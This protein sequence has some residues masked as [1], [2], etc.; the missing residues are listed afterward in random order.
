M[1][2]VKDKSIK[3]KAILYGINKL[4]PSESI[5]LLT[6]IN[7]NALEEYNTYNDIFNNVDYINCTDLQ[8][9]K[10]KAVYDIAINTKKENVNNYKIKNPWDVYKYYMDELRYLKQEV[11]KVVLVNTKNEIIKDMNITK[12]TLTASLV[13]P[14]EVFPFAIKNHSNKIFL[15]HNHPSG[16]IDPSTSDKN[17]TSRLVKCGEII[18]IEILDHII[19]GDGTYFSFKENMVL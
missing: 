15:I 14:R 10:L 12:G 3:D 11:F 1:E 7:K 16:S 6:G 19:I 8:R 4:I 18:G 13:H 17:I 5:S 9:L 2:I